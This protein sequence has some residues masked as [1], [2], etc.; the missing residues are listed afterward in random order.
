MKTTDVVLKWFAK[1]HWLLTCCSQIFCFFGYQNYSKQLTLVSTFVKHAGDKI[2]VDNELFCRFVWSVCCGF[3]NYVWK[4]HKSCSFLTWFMIKKYIL[5][6][7][8]LFMKSLGRKYLKPKIRI[9]PKI[10][11]RHF[12]RSHPRASV[13]RT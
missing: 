9:S 13:R 6:S 7:W 4:E 3:K 8:H 11:S 1:I 5:W 12:M 2:L 10:E